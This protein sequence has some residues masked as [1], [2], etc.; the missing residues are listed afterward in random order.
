MRVVKGYRK[1][2]RE[3]VESSSESGCGG[4]GVTGGGGGQAAQLFQGAA[5]L[6]A[7]RSLR[8]TAYIHTR[9]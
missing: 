5:A 3:P 2:K 4:G 1:A 8:T 6:T 7:S 9:C